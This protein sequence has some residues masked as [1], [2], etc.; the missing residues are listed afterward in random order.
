MGKSKYAVAAE[1]RYTCGIYTDCR[2]AIEIGPTRARVVWDAIEW[3]GSTGH[4]RTRVQYATLAQADKV[5]AQYRAAVAAV[6]GDTG[7][8]PNP[9]DVI[10]GAC[11]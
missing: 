8:G 11:A 1:Y 5:L 3:V 9:L 4:L 10:T 6:E 2:A 7:Y